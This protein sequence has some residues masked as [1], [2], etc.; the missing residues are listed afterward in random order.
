MSRHPRDRALAWRCEEETIREAFKRKKLSAYIIWDPSES[1]VV[2]RGKIRWTS[3]QHT[4][5]DWGLKASSAAG[6]TAAVVK[7]EE[8][9]EFVIEAGALILAGNGVCCID[10]FDKIDSKEQV[11]IHELMEQQTISITKAGV[12]ATLNARVSILAASNPVGGRY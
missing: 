11:A 5:V 1:A 8:S 2:R 7:D 6:F 12:K 10:E 3:Y 4:T 9:F